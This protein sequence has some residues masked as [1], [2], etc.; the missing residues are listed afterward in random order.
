[1]Q[2]LKKTKK[3]IVIIK[4][5]FFLYPVQVPY[6]GCGKSILESVDVLP[7]QKSNQAKCFRDATATAAYRDAEA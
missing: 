1:M 6:S 7:E 4:R 3:S 5:R 2:G